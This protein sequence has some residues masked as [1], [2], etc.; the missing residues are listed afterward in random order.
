MLAP[1]SLSALSKYKMNE[2][3]YNFINTRTRTLVGISMKVLG[4]KR[5]K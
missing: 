4:I 1:A 2:T 5:V 3:S